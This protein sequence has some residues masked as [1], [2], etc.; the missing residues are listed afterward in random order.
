MYST[1]KIGEF[2][3][4]CYGV[5]AAVEK[6]ESVAGEGVCTYGDIIH[7]SC[8]VKRF[9]DIGV[10]SV[11]ALKDIE[12]G[13]TVVF[14]AH[15]V[16]KSV[17]NDAERRGLK[18]VDAT[19]PFVAKIHHIVRKASENGRKVVVFGNSEHPEVKGIVGWCDDAVVFSGAEEAYPIGGDVTLVVQT[20]YDSVRF[21]NSLSA[22]S[23]LFPGAE[24][25][26]TICPATKQRQLAAVELANDSD[27]VIVVGDRKSSNTKELFKICSAV[28][29]AVMVE[30]A[31][32]LAVGEFKDKHRIGVIGGA[33]TPDDLITEV[34][35]KLR[36]ERN[37]NGE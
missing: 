9:S 10:R 32:D 30:S 28:T 19:C 22:I 26:N 27:L 8:V 33:S 13:G 2:S 7:N 36:K 18:V 6:L 29:D 35:Q 23:K 11:S 3:G 37:S 12:E 21:E 16:P 34:I 24:V 17:Y 14:R 1:I 15:G 5:R 31:F 20:T 4:F 25:H